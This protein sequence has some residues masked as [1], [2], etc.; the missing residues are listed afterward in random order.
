MHQSGGLQRL[1][2]LF[3]RQPGGCQFAQFIIDQRQELF[4]RSRI[5]SFKL[6]ENLSEVG[7]G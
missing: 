5:A 1:S 7:H 6:P 4:G 3:V 2:R